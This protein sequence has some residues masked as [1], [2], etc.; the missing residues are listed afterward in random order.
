M[1]DVARFIGGPEAAARFVAAVSWPLERQENRDSWAPRLLAE[2]DMLASEADQARARLES[3]I[4][5]CVRA[6]SCQ[7]S[8]MQWPEDHLTRCRHCGSLPGGQG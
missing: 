8:W 5:T 7:H 3:A 4:A 1:S 6:A 2:P